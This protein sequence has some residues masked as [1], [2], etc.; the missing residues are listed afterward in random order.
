MLLTIYFLNVPGINFKAVHSYG[1]QTYSK[2]YVKRPLSKIQKIGFITNYR[3]MQ[4]KSI[5]ECSK[6]S[7]LR[8]FR[9]SL[10]YHLL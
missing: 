7:T 9:P 6:G 5:A 1:P 8:Y 4:V 10:S 3:L 2:S